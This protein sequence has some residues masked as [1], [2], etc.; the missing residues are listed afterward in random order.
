MSSIGSAP[1]KSTKS[2]IIKGFYKDRTLS[3]SFMNHGFVQ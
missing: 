1:Y 2:L 3:L